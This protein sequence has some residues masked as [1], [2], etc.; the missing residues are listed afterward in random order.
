MAKSLIVGAGLTGAVI[1][2]ILANNNEQILVIDRKNHIAGNIYDYKDKET[3]ITIHK[4]GPHI[5]HTN[6]KRVWDYLSK[7]T[8][9]NF[10]FN[11][12]TN[13]LYVFKMKGKTYA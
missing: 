5:F 11:K 13:N 4:Y 1:A 3:G 2:N 10:F 12:S 8:K 9:W 6:N 7:F